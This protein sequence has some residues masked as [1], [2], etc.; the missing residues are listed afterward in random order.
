MAQFFHPAYRHLWFLSALAMLGMLVLGFALEKLSGQMAT[1]ATFGFS[2]ATVHASAWW[3][4]YH[5]AAL[6]KRFLF[7]VLLLGGAILCGTAGRLAFAYL[8]N[9]NTGHFFQYPSHLISRI[10]AW[11][12]VSVGVNGVAKFVLRWDLVRDNICPRTHTN[13]ADL[14][15]MTAILG[16]IIAVFTPQ[17]V[18]TGGVDDRTILIGSVLLQTVILI[19][20]TM[21][22]L[23]P[24][25]TQTSKAISIAVAG[26]VIVGLMLVAMSSLLSD[27]F[28]AI[29]AVAIGLNSLIFP[30]YVA[31][32]AARE[33][34]FAL[35]S[36]WCP[37]D[38]F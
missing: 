38:T 21:V 7:C 6:W 23:R 9:D 26:L 1:L 28:A 4:T 36:G 20:L 11:W 31:L 37:K 3:F 12:L 5:A 29:A 19:P 13:I 16:T 25:R 32:L 10:A 35:V 22:T 15:Q 2:A 34:H 18:A 27:D 30:F 17:N 14:L 33:S 24:L 8:T